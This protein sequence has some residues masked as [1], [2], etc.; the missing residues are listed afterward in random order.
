MMPTLGRTMLPLEKAAEY[1]RQLRRLAADLPGK[2]FEAPV[3]VDGLEERYRLAAIDQE[4]SGP[5]TKPQ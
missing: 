1:V 4:I 5:A 2:K 3:D